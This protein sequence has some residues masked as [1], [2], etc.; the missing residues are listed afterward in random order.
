MPSVHEQLSVRVR[1]DHVPKRLLI[2]VDPRTC[3][4]VEEWRKP[5]QLEHRIV[6]FRVVYGGSAIEVCQAD[7]VSGVEND[8]S[9][10]R[11]REQ[12][13]KPWSE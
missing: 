7:A 12:N 8:H 9:E 2:R 5:E 3:C 13:W 11:D 4:N 10:K 6:H 1:V